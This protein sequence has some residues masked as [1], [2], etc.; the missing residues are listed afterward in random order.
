MAREGVKEMFSTNMSVRKEI[1]GSLVLSLFGVGFLLYDLKYP[2]DQWANPGPG[3]FPLMVGAVLVILAAW[4][5]VQ[6][7]RKPKPQEAKKNHEGTRK[8]IT[9]FLQRYRVEAN[10][11]LMIAVFIVYLLMVKWV[12]FFISNFLFVIISSKLIGA[13]DWGRPIA[14]ST[15]VNLFCYFLFEVWLKL[16]L[17]RGVLF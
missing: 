9:E 1:A 13:R 6:D 15:G 7:A 3:V 5:L 14:L 4:Q 11:L 12:G 2:L 16:S 17:P 8:S 10:P